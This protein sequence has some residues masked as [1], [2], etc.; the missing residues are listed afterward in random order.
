[1]PVGISNRFA[2]PWLSLVN[3]SMVDNLSHIC[4]DFS[5]ISVNLGLPVKSV[6]HLL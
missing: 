6:N 4:F 5:V 2:E 1:M 3:V